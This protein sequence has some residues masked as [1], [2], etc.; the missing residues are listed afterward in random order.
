M[1]LNQGQPLNR[2]RERLDVLPAASDRLV[3]RVVLLQSD[4]PIPAVE[5][6]GQSAA[7]AVVQGESDQDD[8]V[9]LQ[10]VAVGRVGV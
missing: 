7:A 4:R 1:C 5:K 6:P 9:V 8:R 3:L 2:H 10:P